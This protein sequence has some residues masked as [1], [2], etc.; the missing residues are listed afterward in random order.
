MAENEDLDP[1][2][3][4]QNDPDIIRAVEEHNAA[5]SLQPRECLVCSFFNNIHELRHMAEVFD[6]VKIVDLSSA[7]PE[8]LSDAMVVVQFLSEATQYFLEGL[9]WEE[10]E[11]DED[12]EGEE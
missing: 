5:C 6:S 3:Q 4:L 9:S 11:E 1:F 8:F 7:P 2:D 12:Y 10:D